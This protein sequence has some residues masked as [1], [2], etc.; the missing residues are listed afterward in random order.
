LYCFIDLVLTFSCYV[1]F[2][3]QQ[4]RF[5]IKP[6]GEYNYLNQSG[7]MVVEG[8]DDVQGKKAFPTVFVGIFVT[9]LTVY[10]HCM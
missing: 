9:V 7:C 4:A 6:P 10:T 5:D 1:F 8:I 2:I 3:A